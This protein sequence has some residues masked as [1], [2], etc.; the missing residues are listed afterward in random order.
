MFDE[1]E[2]MEEMTTESYLETMMTELEGDGKNVN[3]KEKEKANEKEKA[4]AS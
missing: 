4:P 3:E 2:S 1:M